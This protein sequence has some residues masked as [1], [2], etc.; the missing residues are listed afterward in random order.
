MEGKK[1]IILPVRENTSMNFRSL[2]FKLPLNYYDIIESIP[3]N[4]PE[5][6]EIIESKLQF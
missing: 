5:K 2:N 1:V 3:K 6:Y 4:P